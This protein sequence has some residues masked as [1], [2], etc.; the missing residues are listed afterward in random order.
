VHLSKYT[1]EAMHLDWS[2]SI[3]VRPD[4]LVLRGGRC[5]VALSLLVEQNCDHDAGLG[6]DLTF[7]KE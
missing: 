3:D 1:D 4:S 7:F 2:L 5:W 6:P